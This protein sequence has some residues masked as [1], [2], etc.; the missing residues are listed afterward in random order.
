MLQQ[1]PWSRRDPRPAPSRRSHR[2]AS[3]RRWQFGWAVTP[4]GWTRLEGRE[5]TASGDVQNVDDAVFFAD[6]PLPRVLGLRKT[7]PPTRSRI[8]PYFCF[9]CILT[10][11]A[12]FHFFGLLWGK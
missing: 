11:L 10:R 4:A 2:L 8:F 3:A 7:H 9:G 12:T 5:I 6:F 1:D